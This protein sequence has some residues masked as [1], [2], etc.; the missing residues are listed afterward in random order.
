MDRTIFESEVRRLRV[1]RTVIV[2]EAIIN[3]YSVIDTGAEDRKML[4]GLSFDPLS[5]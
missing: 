3:I 1:Q 4:H 5:V 2:V